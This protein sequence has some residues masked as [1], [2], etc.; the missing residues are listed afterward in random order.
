MIDTVTLTDDSAAEE[1]WTWINDTLASNADADFL[2]VAG[3]FPVWSI[4]EHGPTSIL[5]SRLKPVLETFK[6]SA[7][8]AGHD[9]CAQY[10]D[11]GLG[12]QYH[13]LGAGCVT[14]PST[15]HKDAIPA[16]SLKWHH[17]NSILT[18]LKGAYGYVSVDGEEGIA[19][20]HYGSDGKL[21]YKAPVI[22][23]RV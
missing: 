9:H 19:V 3:H 16:D 5:V 22:R 12:P 21:L 20:S 17:D 11:E 6:V 18:E 10:I 7:Y 4:C 1:Q 2:I 23:P 14:D 15:K 8:L 13:G